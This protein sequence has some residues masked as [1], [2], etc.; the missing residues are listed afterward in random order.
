MLG[1]VLVAVLVAALVAVLGSVLVAVLG[2][3][4]VVHCKVWNP[5]HLMVLLLKMRV[6]CVMV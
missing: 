2:S 5:S 3:V 1:S 6:V 4:L